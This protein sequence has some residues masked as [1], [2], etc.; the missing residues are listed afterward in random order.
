MNLHITKIIPQLPLIKFVSAV[1]KSCADYGRGII[2][3]IEVHS[4]MHDI[5]N[6]INTEKDFTINL[7]QM[8]K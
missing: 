5:T 4:T 1:E 3:D 2:P 8:N 7:I 6:N